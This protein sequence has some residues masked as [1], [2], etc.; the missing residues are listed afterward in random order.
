M[1]LQTYGNFEI[2][3]EHTDCRVCYYV[4]VTLKDSEVLGLF[5]LD[6]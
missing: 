6:K 4:L 1:L 5:P 2:F 3:R